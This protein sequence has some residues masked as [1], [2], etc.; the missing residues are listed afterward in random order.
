[1]TQHTLPVSLV[2]LD[3][4]IVL[5]VWLYQDPATPALRQ[6]IENRQIGWIATDPMREELRRVLDYPHIAARRQ[7]A[8]LTVDQ[9]MACFDA[10]AQMK[11][12]ALRAPYVCKDADDQ[13]FIDLAVAHQATLLSKDKQVLKMTRRLAALGVPVRT[14]LT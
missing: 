9:F 1:M 3:T 6:A 13:K 11:T 8:P 14:A 7:K 5:D 10:H 4:N 2:V 12:V